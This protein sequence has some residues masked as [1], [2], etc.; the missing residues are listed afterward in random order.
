M[1]RVRINISDRFNP[2]VQIRPSVNTIINATKYYA[3]PAIIRSYIRYI[4]AWDLYHD[5]N[6]QVLLNTS[7]EDLEVSFV[8]QNEI[9]NEVESA[10]PL[11]FF[12]SNGNSVPNGTWYRLSDLGYDLDGGMI[13]LN[14]SNTNSW[15]G[16]IG[17]LL[18]KRGTTG[19]GVVNKLY[20]YSANNTVRDIK[21][22]MATIKEVSVP[23]QG[24]TPIS[25]NSDLNNF[26]FGKYDTQFPTPIDAHSFF[27]DYIYDFVENFQ[28][29]ME[30]ILVPKIYF[31]NSNYATDYQYG[32]VIDPRLTYMGQPVVYG[33]SI[34][35][36]LM[37][38]GSLLYN[39]VGLPINSQTKFYIGL[40]GFISG[41]IYIRGTL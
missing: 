30:N 15:L 19:T 23:H 11:L 38:S 40:E 12:T 3:N 18:R 17:Y 4:N 33:Q 22:G 39:A 37:S 8:Y 29:N 1:A 26:D 16:V 21:V 35:T 41:S 6:P 20:I 34:S 31:T 13:Y 32:T 25:W 7:A 14:R 9:V 5:I 2:P 36:R 24:I 10:A 27:S 28:G